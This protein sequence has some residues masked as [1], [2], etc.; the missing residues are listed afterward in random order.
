MNPSNPLTS[1]RQYYLDIARVIAII[2]IMLNHTVSRSF[3]HFNH[4]MEE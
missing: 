1:K 2:A 3:S 4:Q